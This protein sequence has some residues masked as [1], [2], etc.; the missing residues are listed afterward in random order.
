M[1]VSLMGRSEFARA[2]R[3][4]DQ[5]IDV[6]PAYN[7]NVFI[8][9]AICCKKLSQ[10]EQAVDKLS[11][12]ISMFPEYYDAYI[13]RGKLKLKEKKLAEAITDFIHANELSP[14]KPHGFIGLGDCFYSMKD[15]QKAY[16]MFSKAVKLDESLLQSPIC[17]KMV[18]CLSSLMR[19]E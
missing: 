1:A 13:Y 3:Y 8:L 18:S 6:D 14:E 11:S 9:Y 2:L 15:D 16:D 5:V 10:G 12:C 4:F 17:L 7:R 19:A